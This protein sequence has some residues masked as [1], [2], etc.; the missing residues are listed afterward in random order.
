VDFSPRSLFV[1]VSFVVVAAVAVVA[2][3]AVTAVLWG[4]GTR[5]GTAWFACGGGVLWG[6]VGVRGGGE[7]GGGGGGEE[8]PPGHWGAGV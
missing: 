2:V 6:V 1:V 8:V 7:K 3:A 4:A 5:V